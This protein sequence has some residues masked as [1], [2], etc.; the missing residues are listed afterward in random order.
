M[1]PLPTEPGLDRLTADAALADQRRGMLAVADSGNN[2]V[3]LWQ[4]D[5]TPA[6]ADA[7]RSV[8]SCV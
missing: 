4:L 1:R 7:E 6:V 2:R 3:M 8:P 5:Q